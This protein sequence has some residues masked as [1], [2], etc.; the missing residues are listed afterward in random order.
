MSEML[1]Q[2]INLRI[3]ST[4]WPAFRNLLYSKV[5]LRTGRSFFIQ[6][7][8]FLCLFSLRYK[9]FAAVTKEIKF[10][11]FMSWLPTEFLK[12]SERQYATLFIGFHSIVTMF[13]ESLHKAASHQ[14]AELWGIAGFH[15]TSLKFKL[16][17]C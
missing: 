16:Q 1:P 10:Y 5:F 11:F 2:K 9:I 12:V 17:S 13:S 15:M 14:N 4:F 8:L 3:P 6:I 7:R